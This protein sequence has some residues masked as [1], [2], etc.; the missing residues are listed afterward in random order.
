MLVRALCAGC[1]RFAHA[2]QQ[3]RPSGFEPETCGLRVRFRGVQVVPF[4]PLSCC[5]V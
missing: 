1:P 4:S 5:Y 3:L 2:R